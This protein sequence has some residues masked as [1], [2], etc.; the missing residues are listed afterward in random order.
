M[1]VFNNPCMGDS[2]ANISGYVVY[3]N[4]CIGVWKI[5]ES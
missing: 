2:A 1:W 5:V 4:P 3:Y